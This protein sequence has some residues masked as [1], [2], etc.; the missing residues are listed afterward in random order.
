MNSEKLEYGSGSLKAPPPIDFYKLSLQWPPATCSGGVR[1]GTPI[2]TVFTIHGI[3]PQDINDNPI[4]GYNRTSYACYTPPPSSSSVLPT[5]LTPI[6]SNL[7]SLWP[8]LKNPN[9]TA[10]VFWGHEWDK[11]GTCSDYPYDPFRFF[12]SAL[13]LRQGLTSP[14]MGL[15]RG[16]TYTVQQVINKIQNLTQALPEIACNTNRTTGVVQLWEIRLCYNRPASSSQLVNTIRN[17]PH[18]LPVR[19]GTIT[20]PCKTM[21]TNVYFP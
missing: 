21:L 9:R 13:T 5:A 4:P 8:D 18:Q 16:N 6:Q 19:N 1:C 20:G 11:H 15:T 14:V 10:Y 12:D 17:C 2:P 3:W 7:I